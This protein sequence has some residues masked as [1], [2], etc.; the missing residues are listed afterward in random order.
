MDRKSLTARTTEPMQMMQ[1]RLRV[2]GREKFISMSNLNDRQST[3]LKHKPLYSVAV[4]CTYPV[5]C[6]SDKRHTLPPAV[7]FPGLHQ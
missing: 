5:S 3:R 4:A 1:S 7:Q 2:K 6:Y